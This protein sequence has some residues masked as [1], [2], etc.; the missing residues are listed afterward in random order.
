[1]AALDFL[2]NQPIFNASDFV[3]KSGIPA[4]TARRILRLLTEQKMLR[5]IRESVGSRPATYAFPDLMNIAE[6]RK[7]F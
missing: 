1:M 2:F 3:K 5:L 7:V 4:P 6:G